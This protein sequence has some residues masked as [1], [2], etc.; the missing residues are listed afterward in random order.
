MRSD[1]AEV[2]WAEQGGACG[3]KHA[4]LT[5]L[6]TDTQ[7]PLLATHL[8]HALMSLGLYCEITVHSRVSA[9]LYML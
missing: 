3:L 6:I 4:S 2:D 7:T 8:S 9:F 1:G 5:P